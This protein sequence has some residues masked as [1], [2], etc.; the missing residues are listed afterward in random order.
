[1]TPDEDS[2]GVFCSHEN[3]GKQQSTHK[4]SKHA[5]VRML[6]VLVKVVIVSDMRVTT[7]TDEQFA[8]L[9]LPHLVMVVD[10]LGGGDA[11]QR[12]LKSHSVLLAPESD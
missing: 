11:A 1:M 8:M 5:C 10:S 6:E 7:S 4:L 9:C 2:S 3:L 12:L